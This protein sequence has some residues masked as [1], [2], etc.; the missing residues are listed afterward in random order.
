MKPDSYQN[1]S[2]NP[3]NLLEVTDVEPKHESKIQPHSTEVT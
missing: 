1:L 3:R 2:E